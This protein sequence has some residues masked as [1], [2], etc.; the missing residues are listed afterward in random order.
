MSHVA[1]LPEL[2]FPV[3]DDAIEQMRAEY[4]PLTI[5]GIED[6]TGYEAVRSARIEV[7]KKR[8]AVEGVRKALNADALAWQKSVNTEAKRITALLEPIESHLQREEDAYHAEK[9]RVRKEAEL[10]KL[11]ALQKRLD[12]LMALGVMRHPSV[13]EPM[14]DADFGE[15]LADCTREFEAKSAA[16]A[17]AAEERRKEEERLRV[18]RDKLE[19]IKAAQEAELAEKRRIEAERL[20]AERA[21]LE[22]QRQEQAEAQAKIDAE[23]KRLADEQAERE[24]EAEMKRREQEAA[25]RARKE[26]EER[27]QQEAAAALAK[28]QAE[29]AE[30]RRLESLR[31]DHEKLL[32][33]AERVSAIEI[34]EVSPDAADV[35]GEVRMLLANAASRIRAAANMLL[36]SSAA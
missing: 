16:E 22:R 2:K 32:A 13:I 33:V 5:G 1:E 27:Q 14:S 35:A 12:S 4:L 28:S 8:C 9:E 7:K 26:A 31:P 11:A 23:K 36:K 17:A 30:R 3:A 19:K 18:E 6:R 34:P 29:E 25:E 10:A 24:R 20:A 15:F 21:E